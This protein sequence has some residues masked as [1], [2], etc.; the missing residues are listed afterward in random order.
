[1]ENLTQHHF[2][3]YEYVSDSEIY[4]TTQ[5]FFLHELIDLQCYYA[6][7]IEE[8]DIDDMSKWTKVDTR[9]FKDE[10]TG[11]D[12]YQFYFSVKNDEFDGDGTYYVKFYNVFL[13]KWTI[14]SIKINFNDILAID[15]SWL[16]KYVKFFRERFGF[17]VYPFDLAINVLNR[18][19]NIKFDEPCFDIPDLKEPFTN[20]KLISATHFS[21]NDLLE[22]EV[23]NNI[24]NIYLIVVDVII[25]FALVN[26]LKNKIM[27]VVE[28]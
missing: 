1:M 27:G 6:K 24:H 8:K 19:K 25:V 11:E 3:G 10:L 28:K 13:D 4:I 18:V 7:D 26:L 17:L 16:F 12:T 22:N 15:G 14:S 23:F 20:Q 21:F 9:I 5:K 2:C